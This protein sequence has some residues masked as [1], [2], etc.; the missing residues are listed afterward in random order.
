[1]SSHEA[2]LADVI[3]NPDDDAPRLVCADWLDEHGEAERGE[4]IRVQCRLARLGDAD[5][6]RAEL[7]RQERELLEGHGAEWAEPLRGLVHEFQYRRGFVEAVEVPGVL[8]LGG[9]VQRAMELAPV[10][11]LRLFKVGDE[12]DELWGVGPCLGR[13]RELYL[14]AEDHSYPGGIPDALVPARL[15]ADGRLAGL[16]SFLLD[17]D[18]GEIDPYPVTTL[19]EPGV[20]PRLERLG[21]HL[22]YPEEGQDAEV[23][24][25]LVQVK[26]FASLRTLHLPLFGLTG[27]AGVLGQCPALSALQELDLRACSATEE[28]WRELLW[29]PALRS[30]RR[31]DLGGTHVPDE[32]LRLTLMADTPLGREVLRRFPGVA[33]FNDLDDSPGNLPS[34]QGL[35]FPDEGD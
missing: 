32:N 24:E 7:E 20:L 26:P 21:L 27:Y 9:R 18:D 35:T 33:D 12:M 8:G 23:L 28:D 19:F 6:A 5:P 22:G 10:R 11:C 25:K 29:T 16:K 2:F 30:V 31:L 1:M 4:L 17:C 3:E 13:L 34:W 14:Y 15:F